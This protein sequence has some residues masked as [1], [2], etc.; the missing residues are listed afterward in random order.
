VTI[1]V[2]FAAVSQ[3][4]ADITTAMNNMDTQLE[5]LKTAL[6]PMIAEWSG[7]AQEQYWI[8]QSQWD[9]AATEIKEL[10]GN[11]SAKV[12]LAGGRMVDTETSNTNIW[13]T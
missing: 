1:K 2:D 8:R 12:T 9:T 4:A 5:N 7:P 13:A 3:A 11:Y 6:A 10:L